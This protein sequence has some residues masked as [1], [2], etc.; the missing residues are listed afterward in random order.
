MNKELLQKELEILINEG[1]E[2]MV[3]FYYKAQKSFRFSEEEYKIIKKYGTKDFVLEKAY[4]SFYTRT[5]LVLS[6]IL[7][8]R[9]DEFKECYISNNPNTLYDISRYLLHVQCINLKGSYEIYA[10]KQFER[11][12]GFLEAAKDLI[13][14]TC[15]NIENDIRYH[16]YIDELDAAE[17]LLKRNYIRAAG[18]VAGV[19]LENHLK[20]VCKSISNID[21]DGNETLSKYNALLKNQIGDI[22]WGRIDAISRIRNLCDHAK[23]SN[24][25]KN[26]VQFLINETKEIIREVTPHST[27]NQTHPQ[28]NEQ[29]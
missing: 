16:V 20:V 29:V 1:K 28:Q 19:V 10:I 21:L 3:M 2:L 26:D 14:T 18:S 6:K 17:H 15:Y 23:D 8:E 7:P 24:P 11:Q 4:N 5:L 25:T 27:T 22:L 9:L 12:L 13:N